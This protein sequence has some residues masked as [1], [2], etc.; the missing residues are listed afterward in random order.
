MSCGCQRVDTAKLGLSRLGKKG[1]KMSPE[2]VEK[3]RTR[4]LKQ[5]E[6]KRIETGIDFSYERNS[7][8]NRSWAKAVKNRDD[9]KCKIANDNC[10]GTLEAHH[11]LGWKDYPELRYKLNNGISLCAFHHPNKRDDEVR[12]SPYFQSLIVDKAQ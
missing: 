1:Q 3:M 7:Y 8:K 6:Q 11:I 4:L 2:T 9:W 12:L 5:W 10:S